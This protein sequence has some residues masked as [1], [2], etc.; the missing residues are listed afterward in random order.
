MIELSEIDDRRLLQLR[1]SSR[2][3]SC[4]P[5]SSSSGFSSNISSS[6]SC[7]E[8]VSAR[9]SFKFQRYDACAD[10]APGV[11][12]DAKAHH[13]QRSAGV[14]HQLEE[15]LTHFLAQ[16][17]APNGSGTA[18]LKSVKGTIKKCWTSVV[19]MPGKSIQPT[20]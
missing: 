5:G 14:P 8:A 9:I 18:M 4:F 7:A 20:R 11:H 3:D 16:P 19:G 15:L 1:E 2:S 10:Q 17:E 12:Q 13:R 6:I